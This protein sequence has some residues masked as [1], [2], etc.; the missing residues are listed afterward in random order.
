MD[1][2]G[3]ATKRS[4]IESLASDLRDESEESR[5]RSG[6]TQGRPGRGGQEAARPMTP[7]RRPPPPSTNPRRSPRLSRPGLTKDFRR[8]PFSAKSDTR[9]TAHSRSASED[10]RGR[11]ASRSSRS[12]SDQGWSGQARRSREPTPPQF[13][14]FNID[15]FTVVLHTSSSSLFTSAHPIF[16][17]SVRVVSAHSGDSV[18][19][20]PCSQYAEEEQE[21]RRRERPDVEPG[22]VR[23]F[24]RQEL[25]KKVGHSQFDKPRLYLHDL[26]EEREPTL[27]RGGDPIGP[28]PA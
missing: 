2:G 28:R 21:V 24:L 1:R 16:P 8:L 4:K 18:R 22:E 25:L 17:G 27:I 11:H 3:G 9:W 13:P 20:P 23:R 15:D 14:N 6:C 12:S 19:K 10:E 5:S 26:A 7:P